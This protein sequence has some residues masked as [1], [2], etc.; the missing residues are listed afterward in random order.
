MKL[1]FAGATHTKRIILKTPLKIVESESFCLITDD[2]FRPKLDAV[3]TRH[4][5]MRHSHENARVKG[6]GFLHSSRL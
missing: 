5:V 2:V 4:D 3:C 1:I 6:R